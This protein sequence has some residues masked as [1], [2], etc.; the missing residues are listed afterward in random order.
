MENTKIIVKH[1]S[2]TWDKPLILTDEYEISAEATVDEWVALFKAILHRLGYV[3]ESV[4]SIFVP[5]D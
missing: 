5:Q 2:G 3:T 4:D 1:D